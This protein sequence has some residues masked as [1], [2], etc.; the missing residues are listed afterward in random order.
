MDY[1]FWTAAL[2]EEIPKLCPS[3]CDNIYPSF[4]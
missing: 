1:V 2:L 4:L 3:V